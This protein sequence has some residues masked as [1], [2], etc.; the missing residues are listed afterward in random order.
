MGADMTHDEERIER[1]LE[2]R[3]AE[4]RDRAARRRRLIAY[5][6]ASALC[7]I[8]VGLAVWI[9]RT[10]SQPATTATVTAPPPLLTPP[11]VVEL[12]DRPAP[13][14]PRPEPSARARARSR[15]T[16]SNDTLPRPPVAPHDAD[17]PDLSASV[18]PLPASP[19]MSAPS[20]VTHETPAEAPREA[21][22]AIEPPSVPSAPSGGAVAVAP[23]TARER[24]TNWAKGEV[25]EFRDGVKR[26][27][28]EFRSGYEKVR[29]FFKR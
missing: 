27:V 13:A 10:S 24:V 4:Q 1:Y 25:Q 7:V 3:R 18:A 17:S 23:P 6:A 15:P 29:G 12:P 8:A 9:G 16:P 19:S 26:E 5:A 28:N 21:P 22:S 14:L 2:W 20:E 11:P